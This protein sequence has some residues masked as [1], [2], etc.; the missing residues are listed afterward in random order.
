RAHVAMADVAHEADAPEV[1]ADHGH[2]MA[3]QVARGGE[4][5]AV[6]ADHH[7]E[8]G[9]GAER[10]VVEPLAADLLG[11]LFFDASVAAA[12]FEERDELAQRCTDLSAAEIAEQ[13]GAPVGWFCFGWHAR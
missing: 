9:S 3:H 1:D 8:I 2:A 13:L 6:A 12:R 4:Q 5:R 7:R 10:G 11:G